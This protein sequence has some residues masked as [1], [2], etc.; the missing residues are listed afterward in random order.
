MKREQMAAFSLRRV[1]SWVEWLRIRRLYGRAFPREERKPFA[2][3]RRMH[4]KG[5]TD[6][7]VLRQDGRFVGFASTINGD[8]LILLD[9]LAVAEEMR[10]RGVGS[11]ALAALAEAYPGQGLFVEIESAFAPGEDQPQRLRRR[12]FYERAG[13]VPC[14][15]MASVFG[16]PMELLG[17]GCCVDFPAY[18]HFY[19]T[20]YSAWA[21]AHILP[22]QWPDGVDTE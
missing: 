14:R 17:R 20:H 8:G 21:G 22:L 18:H 16:V 6:V 19:C 5:K 4:R 11:A 13:F 10:G 12:A 3:I 9:Y 1:S 7:W 15:T 2:I